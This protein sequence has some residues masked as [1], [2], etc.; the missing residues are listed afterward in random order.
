MSLFCSGGRG[1]YLHDL[2][3]HEE[4]GVEGG[5][6]LLVEGLQGQLDQTLLQEH[7]R[8]LQVVAPPS[9]TKQ[10]HKITLCTRLLAC[11]HGLAT[12]FNVA[13]SDNV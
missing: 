5:V 13:T 2:L 11:R 7:G 12:L 4:G 10:R 8:A 1:Y 3:A 9:A 6:A